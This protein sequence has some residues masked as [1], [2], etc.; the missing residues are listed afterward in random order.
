MLIPSMPCY[1]IEHRI[2]ALQT[3]MS[4]NGFDVALIVQRADLFYFSDSGQATHVLVPSDGPPFLMVRGNFDRAG[5]DSPLEEVIP[6]G[7]LA[8][9]RKAVRA[10]LPRGTKPWGWN[11]MCS[12]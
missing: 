11:L 8:D 9:V 2:E 7:S 6:V 12:P 1:E 3:R 5:Q 4:E 10:R